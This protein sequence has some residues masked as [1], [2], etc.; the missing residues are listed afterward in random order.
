MESSGQVTKT[1]EMMINDEG[2]DASRTCSRWD[3]RTGERRHI[4]Q[5]SGELLRERSSERSMPSGRHLVQKYDQSGQ[6]RHSG[7]SRSSNGGETV[8]KTSHGE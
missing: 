4:S 3:K 7:R 6:I 8:A 5:Y 1:E 2:N